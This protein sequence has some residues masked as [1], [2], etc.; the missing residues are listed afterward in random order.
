MCLECSLKIAEGKKFLDEYLKKKM[1]GQQY[2]LIPKF[3]LGV[4][5]TEEV[6]ET[7][8]RYSTHP[9]ELLKER[10]LEQITEDEKEILEFLGELKDVLTYNFLFFS[11]PNPQVFKINLLVEDILPSRISKIFEAKKEAEKLEIFKNIKVGR[12]QYENIEFRFDELRRFITFQKSFLE[13]V[14]K[15][16]RGLNIEPNLL[17]SWFMGRIRQ[18][19]IHDAYLK[20]LVL[21]A[22]VSFLFFK[23]LGIMPSNKT[24]NKKGGEFMNELKEKA[25]DFFNNFK[26][27]FLTPA[28]IAVF[29]LGAFT[30]KLLNIQYQERGSTPFWKNLKRLKMGERDFKCLL[31]KIQNKL[32]EYGK[33]YYRSLESLISEYF[34]EAGKNWQ[35]STD[36]LNFYFVLGMN[37]VDEVDK[38]LNLTKEKEG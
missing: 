20:F 31:P 24:L 19:F 29:L 13:V 10:T 4:E 22:F 27:T 3:I 15:T 8:F 1:G 11:A 34:L 26:D 12:N 38:V 18:E 9:E 35:I 30:Q 16:F 33:N 5:G 14:D 17:F 28:H 37:L 25:E 32:E 23:K 21:R 6:I 2:Y 36:E 7:F